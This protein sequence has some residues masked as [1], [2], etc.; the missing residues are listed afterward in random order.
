LPTGIGKPPAFVET[1]GEL[2]TACDVTGVVLIADNA[3]V[4]DAVFDAFEEALLA[5]HLYPVGQF[6]IIGVQVYPVGQA[7]WACVFAGRM[8]TTIKDKTVTEIAR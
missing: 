8:N 1:F 5:I 6:T 4:R 7:T 2:R 3:F